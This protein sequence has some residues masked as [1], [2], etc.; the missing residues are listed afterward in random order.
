MAS[1]CKSVE[2][3]AVIAPDG[4]RATQVPQL[5][6]MAG[7]IQDVSRP[8]SEI[9][10][11]APNSQISTQVPQARQRFGFTT[12]VKAGCLSRL[13]IQAFARDAPAHPEMNGSCVGLR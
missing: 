11:G 10:W 9:N 5:V 6:Q 1:I 12:D 7:S 4:Q 2:Y 3:P 8:F 13:D